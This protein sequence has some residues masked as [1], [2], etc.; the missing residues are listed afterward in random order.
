MGVSRTPLARSVASKVTVTLDLF[1]PFAL[2]PGE[3]TAAVVGATPS[4]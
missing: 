4:E 1:Q 3:T 2:A